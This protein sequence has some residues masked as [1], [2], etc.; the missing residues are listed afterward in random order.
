[1]TGERVVLGMSGG[2]DSSVAALA[3]REAGCDVV[4]VWLSFV[5]GGDPGRARDAAAAIGVP[6]VERD[7][8]DL[9]R[10]AVIEPSRAEYLAGRTPNP[11]ARC[12]AAAKLALLCEEA[13]ARGA[14]RAATG[15]YARIGAA[16]SG[17]PALLRG[18]DRDKDQSYFLFALSAG[19]LSRVAFPLGNLSKEEVRSRAAAAG[20]PAAD[21]AESQDCC[22]D[23][24]PAG[25]REEWE[26]VDLDG[27]AIGRHRGAAGL[28]VG[29]RRGVGA[30]SSRPLYVVRID[31][32]ARRVAVGPREALLARRLVATLDGI[33]A[34]DLEEEARCLCKIRYRHEAAPAVARRLGAARVEVV[35]DEPQEAPTPGQAAVLYD[36]ERVLAGGWIDEARA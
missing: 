14:A 36:G 3:L 13:D 7:A 22:F 32:G 2:V 9:F 4:G 34:R 27:R 29:Q 33:G 21:A 31:A 30:A 5:D 20:L 26:I 16:P 35:F 18:A 17:A 8:R 24:V 12:N 19:Q 25:D 28:T 15:H 10:A 1:M 11:C 23:P 6:L